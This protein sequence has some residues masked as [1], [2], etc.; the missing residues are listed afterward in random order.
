MG[1]AFVI[2]GIGA[3]LVA[4]E[5]WCLD[6]AWATAAALMTVGLVVALFAW[7]IVSPRA[8][9]LV[10]TR[11]RLN[12]GE[13]AFTFDDGPD[14]TYTPRVLEVLA[15]H[16]ARAT[17]FV[18]GDRAAAHPELVRRIEAEGHLLGTHTQHHSHLFHLGTAAAMRRDIEAGL[19]SVER[20]VGHR[21]TLFR[22]PQGLRT[23]LLRDALRALPALV[24]VT[25]TERGLDAM[26]RSSARIVAR[27]EGALAPGAI[28]TLHDGAGLGGTRDRDATVEALEVLLTRA[29]SRGLACVTLAEL[30]PR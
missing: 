22:P 21:P 17:F 10:S 5:L 9:V 7:A 19:A 4:L 24:C 15:R 26:G 1:R 14:P 29:K 30:D 18:V 23:P 28:L 20:I 12:G 3:A 16:Q 27:L 11:W 6:G 13:V 8:Q 2:K 25:W